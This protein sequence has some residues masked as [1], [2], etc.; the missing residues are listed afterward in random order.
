MSILLI[1]LGVGGGGGGVA[2]PLPYF[3]SGIRILRGAKQTFKKLHGKAQLSNT[4]ARLSSEKW[5]PGILH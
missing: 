1:S 3:N 2:N 5:R 4:M